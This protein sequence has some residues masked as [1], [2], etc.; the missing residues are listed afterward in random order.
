MSESLSIS[1]LDYYLK[2]P[3]SSVFLTS[4]TRSNRLLM[5]ATKIWDG[6]PKTSVIRDHIK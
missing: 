1:A 6:G 3:V 5:V 2:S 4:E